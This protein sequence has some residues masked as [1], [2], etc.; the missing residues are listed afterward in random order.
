MQ[1]IGEKD[2]AF[3][4]QNRINTVER[5]NMGVERIDEVW[6][7]KLG[8]HIQVCEFDEFIAFNGTVWLKGD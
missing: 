7:G 5:T 6:G 1:N 4:I 8:H 2:M 3:T